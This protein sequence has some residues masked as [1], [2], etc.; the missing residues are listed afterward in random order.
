M[1]YCAVTFAMLSFKDSINLW[2]NTY[3]IGHY[4]VLIGMIVLP[5]IPTYR[6]KKKDDTPAAAPAA[7]APEA[8]K[9]L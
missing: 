6:P 2:R 5:L 3:F 1:N 9:T 7:P 8:K 4:H